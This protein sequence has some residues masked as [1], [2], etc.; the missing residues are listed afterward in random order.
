GGL[1]ER[2]AEPQRGRLDAAVRTLI[3]DKKAFSPQKTHR[4][5]LAGERMPPEN[6]VASGQQCHVRP[7]GAEGASWDPRKGPSTN[8]PARALRAAA[9]SR[10]KASPAICGVG[11]ESRKKPKPFGLD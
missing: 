8:D 9:A 1:P 5:S 4:H 3:A 10:R 7:G 2:A 11:L 6:D